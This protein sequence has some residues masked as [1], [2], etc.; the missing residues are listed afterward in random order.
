M[1]EMTNLLLAAKRF[2]RHY[3]ENVRALLDRENDPYI[4]PAFWQSVED[5]VDRYPGVLASLF[6]EIQQLRRDKKMLLSKILKRDE[7]GRELAQRVKE[8]ERNVAESIVARAK[9]E[10][11]IAELEVHAEQN[12]WRGERCGRCKHGA[13]QRFLCPIIR[14][15]CDSKTIACP[16]WKPKEKEG[17]KP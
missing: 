12:A 8:L 16:A 6:R 13:Q 17:G 1:A 5:D 7:W 15:W 14:R 2:F 11:I 3:A 9:Y 4:P 10:A